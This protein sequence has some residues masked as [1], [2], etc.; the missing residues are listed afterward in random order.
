LLLAYGD[1]DQQ[2]EE[3]HQPWTSHDPAYYGGQFV[4]DDQ[5]HPYQR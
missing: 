2:D 3:P 4:D 1:L 5:A